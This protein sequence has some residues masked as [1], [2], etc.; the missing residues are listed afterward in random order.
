M[1]KMNDKIKILIVDDHPLLREA[2]RSTFETQGDFEIVG[3]ASDG[4]EA[5]RLSSE[6][7]PDV[8]IMDII[9][10]RLTG[11]EAT[12]QIRKLCPSTAVLILTAYDDDRYVV[13]LLEAGAAGYL[14]KSSR[15]QVLV[16]AVR[17][18]YAGESV[19]H[20][21][22]IAKVLKYSI[23]TMGEGRH[24]QRE[25]QLSERELEVLKLAAQG[26]SNKEIAEKLSLSVRTVKAHLSSIFSKMSVASRTEAIVKGV[27]EGWLTLDDIVA[28]DGEG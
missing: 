18:V 7:K 19:L 11:I 22:I 27:R 9:M 24:G 17:T 16:D 28:S 1:L 21:D 12:R 26:K 10:P 2:M 6:L 3:E 5:V 4:E 25:D 13:G 15:G 20:P 8:I 23:R 14:L